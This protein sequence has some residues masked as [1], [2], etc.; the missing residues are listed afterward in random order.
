MAGPQ[1]A[2]APAPA[3]TE[4]NDADS[5]GRGRRAEAAASKRTGAPG[6]AGGRGPGGF[7]SGTQDASQGGVG[8]G[9]GS[10]V[11]TRSFP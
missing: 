5:G 11:S 7:V 2:R 6:W 9:V 8:V 1:A 4:N 3:H 10:L